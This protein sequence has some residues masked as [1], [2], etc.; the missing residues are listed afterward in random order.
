MKTCTTCEWLH[1]GKCSNMGVLFMDGNRKVVDWESGSDA[2][3]KHEYGEWVTE[4]FEEND[5]RFRIG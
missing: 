2:C 1:G 4:I 3:E 5:P